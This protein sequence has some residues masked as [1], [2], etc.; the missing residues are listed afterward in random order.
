MPNPVQMVN[1]MQ[2]AN[3]VQVIKTM[4]VANPV[5][6]IKT[7]QVANPVQVI[8][9]MQVAN[10]VQVIKPMQVANPVQ[11]ASLEH[12]LCF[13]RSI[14]VQGPVAAAS[15]PCVITHTVNKGRRHTAHMQLGESCFSFRFFF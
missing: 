10:P 2:R 12:M 4:Q 9:T 6:V 8:K 14:Q 1:L 15:G 13:Q 3:P 5:Q 11:V 7:M